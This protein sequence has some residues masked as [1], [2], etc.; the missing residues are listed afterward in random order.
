MCPNARRSAS[1][2]LA[3]SVFTYAREGITITDTHGTIIDVNDTSRASRAIRAKRPS[4][5]PAY[6]E[7]RPGAEFMPPCGEICTPMAT[8]PARC[9]TGKSGEL[10]AEI[11]TI[12]AVRNDKGERSTTWRCSPTSPRSRKTSASWHVAHYDA[13]TGLPNRV[14]LAGP[15]CSSP[16][17]A[18]Q[19][20][21]PG[22]RPW[23]S[24]T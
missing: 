2:K 22:R 20:K 4:P 24:R 10:I 9:G 8:G 23:P 15:A 17:Q 1:S 7:I 3:A 21:W 18:P 14:L 6:T 11:I 12:S 5:K 13:L 19:R 16:R